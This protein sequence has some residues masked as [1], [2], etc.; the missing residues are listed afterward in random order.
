MTVR[1]VLLAG[2][3]RVLADILADVL[4]DSTDLKVTRA[5][6]AG[7]LAA[8]ASAAKAE[9]IIAAHHD[10]ADLAG[11]DPV[12]GRAANL[13]ILAVTPDGMSAY[14]HRIRCETSRI[15]NVTHDGILRVLAE[16]KPVR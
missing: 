2:L 14:L 13:S 3:P 11:I 10:P 15:E 7:D 16:L 8:A 4:Q 5:D 1:T 12:L 6:A 9:V